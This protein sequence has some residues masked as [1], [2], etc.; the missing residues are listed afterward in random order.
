MAT[1]PLFRTFNS[2]SI[3]MQRILE[4]HIVQLIKIHGIDVYYVPKDSEIVG[5]LLGD[6]RDAALNR[7]FPIEGYLSR[8]DAYSGPN[9]LVSKFG[10]SVQS[11]TV[12]V[13][14]A[15]SFKQFVNVFPRPREGDLIYI[16]V[17]ERLFEITKS[18][19]DVNFHQIGRKASEPY[20][21]ELSLETF[22]YSQENIATGIS[23]IDIIDVLNSQTIRLE[24]GAGEGNYLISE[25]VYQ[26]GSNYLTSNASAVVSDW[27]PVD[28]HLSV[29]NLRGEFTG[30]TVVIGVISNTRYT[31]SSYDDRADRVP[32]S[33]QDNAFIQN[34]AVLIL[35]YSENNPLA[36][37]SLI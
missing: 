28:K 22:R 17:L 12:L 23:D 37:S 1:H 9:E 34:D 6:D 10:F 26:G 36:N 19:P 11:G 4:D 7:A 35:D 5:D 20:Y 14:S 24:M 30:N 18:D 13:V 27:N 32:D 2:A 8:F 15:R 25:D 3:N 16:P 31:L 33:Q 21:W 29:I